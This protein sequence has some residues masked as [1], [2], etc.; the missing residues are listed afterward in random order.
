MD[1]DAEAE[2]GGVW[3]T[4]AEIARRKNVSRQAVTKRVA[5]LERDGKVTTR[6]KGNRRE[7]DLAEYDRAVGD[8]GDA[9]KEQAAETARGTDR[10]P[11][12]RDAQT[13]RARYEA[14]LKA[15]DLGERQGQLLPINGDHG[16]EAAAAEIGAAMARALDGF[17]RIADEVAAA[18]SQDGVA[19]ARRVL[20][21]FAFRM[22]NEWADDLSRLTA[23]GNAAERAGPIETVVDEDA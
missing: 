1:P 7:V 20:K 6:R 19:G 13:E 15:L 17:P 16:I 14:R 23:Q 4:C 11:G 10:S 5:Q 9:V 12:Y 2:G 22:R 3:L 18:V 21:E 8:T